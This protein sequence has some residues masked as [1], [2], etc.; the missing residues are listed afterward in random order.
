M[1]DLMP[2][3]VTLGSL[4]SAL[5]LTGCS[6]IQPSS[7]PYIDAHSHVLPEYFPAQQVALFRDTGLSGF[8]IM[9]PDLEPMAEM[10]LGNEGFVFPFISLARLPDM[11]GLRLS[12]T[13]ATTMAAAADA[14]RACGFGEIPT[15]IMPRTEASDALAL[16]NADRV[17]IYAAAD[18]RGLPVNLHIDIASDAVEAAIGTIARDHPN[19]KF[20]LAHAGW[21]AGPDVIARLMNKYA[22]IY[23]DL[24]IRLDPA[25]GL[26]SDPMPVGSAPPGA[27]ANIS[28]LAADGSLLPEW[29]A[30]L[31]T[32]SSRFLFAMDLS[33]KSRPRHAALLLITARRALSRLGR[34]REHAIAHGNIQRLMQNCAG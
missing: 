27:A 34:D 11:P 2:K 9:H 21:S 26:P 1:G 32:H 3:Y 23:A 7:V 31:N 13:A 17:A 30:L 24:S 4:V 6:T 14:R 5:F 18:K 29:R 33:E 12:P 10:Q 16:L 25:E 8:V 20:I 19:A 15:R 22:N 28:I